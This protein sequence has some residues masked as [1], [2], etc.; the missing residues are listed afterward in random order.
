VQLL[1]FLFLVKSTC[2]DWTVGVYFRHWES[3]LEIWYRLE[4]PVQSR[5][6]LVRRQK[7]PQRWILQFSILYA[8]LVFCTP[9]GQAQDHVGPYPPAD[10]EYGS[11]I[12]AAQC[13]GCHG[14]R[15]DQVSG[16]N[17][18]SG[19]FRHVFSDADL[20]SVVTTGIAGTD[21]PPH[22][23]DPPELAAIVAYIRNMSTFYARSVTVGDA[24]RGETLFNGTGNCRSCHR[25]NGQ[26]PRVAP[27]LSNIGTLRTADLLGQTLVDPTGAMLPV[28]RSVRAVTRDGKI[29]TGLRLNEDT[30]TVQL[31]DDQERLVSLEKADLRD[32]SVIKTSSMPSYKDKLNSQ[33]RA[34][35]VAY[36][37]SLKGTK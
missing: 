30:Y 27:D 16:V 2:K 17:L 23:F 11:R 5:V 4:I 19:Q 7:M 25:V 18:R 10:I 6:F 8:V 31:I 13:S 29:I 36:L 24:S 22:S 3:N 34:D 35:V 1:P 28:N 15:G 33:E 21:M 14:L 9:H 26:G 20:R 37:L 12:F 32:Y